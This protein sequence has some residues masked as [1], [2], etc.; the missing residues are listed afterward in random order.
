MEERGCARGQPHGT[1]LVAGITP[2]RTN[3][4]MELLPLDRIEEP[5]TPLLECPGRRVV[6]RKPVP[7]RQRCTMV[8]PD[9]FAELRTYPP[10]HHGNIVIGHLV[11]WSWHRVPL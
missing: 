5:I 7:S 6:E 11:T 3:H 9:G 10:V 4:R 1:R 2:G 8:R